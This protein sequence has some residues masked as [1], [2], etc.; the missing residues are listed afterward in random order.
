MPTK[1]PRERER[2]ILRSIRIRLLH[3]FGIRLFRRNVG[4][5]RD[6]ERFIR[7]AAPGQADLWGIDRHARHWELE[8][9][10]PGK[11]PTPAQLAWLKECSRLGCVAFWSDNANDAERVA[12][13]VLGG[14]RIVWEG[15]DF[16]VEM[17]A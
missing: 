9:K 4:A 12:E 14:G 2:K 3:R 7:F 15:D 11:K 16:Y 1:V 5:L 6:G 8:V 13:A 17:P 10:A